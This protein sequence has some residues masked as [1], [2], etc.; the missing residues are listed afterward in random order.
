MVATRDRPDELRTTV[1]RLRRLPEHPPVVVVDN[2]SC[3]ARVPALLAD[4]DAI[5]G[6]EVVALGRN[7]GAAARTVGVRALETPY[8][9]FADDD[10]WWG[11]GALAEA[12]ALLDARPRLGLVAARVLVGGDGQEDPVNAAMAVS[13]LAG[14]GLPGPRVLGFVACGAVVRRAAYLEVGGFHPRFGIGG[15]EEPLALDLAAAGW[16]LAYVER[17]VAHHHPSAGRNPA[18][19]QRRQLRNAL[20][21]AWLRR[22]RRVLVPRTLALLRGA[23]RGVAARGLADAL[24]GLPWVLSER[25]VLPVAVE[26]EL[27]LLDR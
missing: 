16:E 27:R 11:P 19:R 12:V 9:A 24:G 23:R 18:A 2:G 4:L 14:A 7:A 17:L 5:E 6:V 13:P 15:E 8:V 21:S 26:R 10:S 20:W 1:D 25:R 22:P 3:D